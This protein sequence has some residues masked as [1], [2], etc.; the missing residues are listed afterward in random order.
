MESASAGL[1]ELCGTAVEVPGDAGDWGSEDVMSLSG[2][3][4]EA[5]AVTRTGSVHR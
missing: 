1:V 4:D 2:D 5:A 3:V